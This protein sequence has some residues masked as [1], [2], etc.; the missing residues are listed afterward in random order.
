MVCQAHSKRV[1]YISMLC[2]SSNDLTPDRVFKRLKATYDQRYLIE[3]HV[4]KQMAKQVKNEN[5]MV[6]ANPYQFSQARLR[7]QILTNLT[8]PVTIS[9]GDYKTYTPG[10]RWGGLYTWDSGMHALGLVEY[11]SEKAA[12]IVN[13]YMMKENDPVPAVVHGSPL[14]LHIYVLDEIYKKTQNKEWLAYFY[15]RAVQYYDYFTGQHPIS[16]YDTFK[17]GLL[18]SYYDGYNT[19]GIDDYPAQHFEGE[20]GL[21]GKVSIVSASA[22]A[23]C[24]GDIMLKFATVLK[25]EEDIKRYKKWNDYLGQALQEFS[26]DQ[27]SGYFAHVYDESKEKVMT[28]E[29]V[30]YN[31]GIDGISP[32]L[33]N[34]CT[35]EQKEIL[36]NH[37]MTEG[38]MWTPY[39]ITAVAMDAPY[40]RPDGYWNGKVWI[41]HQ[42]FIWKAFIGHGYLAEAENI[43]M[44]ALRIWERNT[45]ETYNTYEQ[46]DG[47]TGMGEGCHQ[48]AG[49]SAPLAAFYHAYYK[50]GE[51]TLGYQILLHSKKINERSG[52]YE[53][54]LSAPGGQV[55]TGILLPVHRAGKYAVE[56]NGKKEI[57]T[58]ADKRIQHRIQVGKELTNFKITFLD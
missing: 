23:I 56:S 8:Y 49:L 52:Q 3:D 50:V 53:L 28:D 43:A 10:K 17:S 34:I 1:I 27:E 16:K 29:G 12:Q 21:Y 36:V 33:T 35:Q 2:E 51:V 15:P 37:I 40:S 18:N 30:N 9:R 31:M 22:H 19:I 39:G 7:T 4:K 32:I 44:T 54:V 38:E 25:Q 41:P 46:F 14:P 13:Q 58:T 5:Q 57:I 47:Q 24:I 48:F 55:R 45:A 20:N 6:Q 42:W 11:D 26:W